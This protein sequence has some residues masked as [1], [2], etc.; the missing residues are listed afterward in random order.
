MKHKRLMVIYGVLLVFCLLGV[1]SPPV[2]SYLDD[3]LRILLLV[4]DGTGSY[5]DGEVWHAILEASYPGMFEVYNVSENDFSTLNLT[6][7]DLIVDPNVGAYSLGAGNR[8]LLYTYLEAGGHVLFSSISSR[9]FVMDR[10]AV[11]IV[12]RT[13]DE[14]EHFIHFISSDLQ[15]LYLGETQMNSTSSVT[16]MYIPSS[17][18][19]NFTADFDEMIEIENATDHTFI[20]VVWFGQHGTGDAVISLLKTD[21]L[22]YG[23]TGSLYTDYWAPILVQYVEWLLMD[24]VYAR[25]SVFDEVPIII[26]MDDVRETSETI[27]REWVGNASAYE[28]YV[29][30]CIIPTYLV[31]FTA[32]YIT[33]LQSLNTAGYTLAIHGGGFSGHI[34]FTTLGYFDQY[35]ELEEAIRVFQLYLGITPTVFAPPYNSYNGSTITAMDTLGLTIISGSDDINAVSDPVHG[36]GQNEGVNVYS[37]GRS[38]QV[39]LDLNYTNEYNNWFWSFPHELSFWTLGSRYPFVILTHT[40]NNA[41]MCGVALSQYIQY[42]D[43]YDPRT[44]ENA[45]TGSS[46]ADTFT[47][48]HHWRIGEDLP[49]EEFNSIV[50]LSQRYSSS[51][52]EISIWVT[53]RNASRLPLR[54]EHNP[55]QRIEEVRVNGSIISLQDG[56]FTRSNVLQPGTYNIIIELG[57]PPWPPWW[58]DEWNLFIGLFGLGMIV[59][60]PTYFLFRL[61]EGEWEEGLTWFL[62]C[63][64][65]GVGLLIAWLWS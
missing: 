47:F 59:V 17:L 20:E 45:F 48:R 60:S 19:A 53:L 27:V 44:L 4:S 51:S 24:Y 13:A 50:E 57:T 35:Y 18:P 22:T 29:D 8:T 34:D 28:F 64:V 11:P 62:V 31:N 63:F 26:R 56:N 1:T 25:P 10:Y 39:F 30:L 41:S 40:V 23:R 12:W 37:L 65:L 52:Q 3:N 58:L 9:N 15:N 14:W 46:L 36:M 32:D 43:A 38:R 6:V 2:S 16:P 54:V 7:Y 33:Y 21:D 55:F 5:Y 49:P 61:K 42:Y